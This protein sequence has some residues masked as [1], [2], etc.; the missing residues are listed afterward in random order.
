MTRFFKHKHLFS[1]ALTPACYNNLAML[2][3]IFFL[4]MPLLYVVIKNK[5]I[6]KGERAVHSVR[7]LYFVFIQCRGKKKKKELVRWSD[8]SSRLNQTS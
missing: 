4:K 8:C 7:L 3:F 1:P 6:K 5:L 2:K